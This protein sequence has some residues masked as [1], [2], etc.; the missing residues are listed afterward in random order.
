MPIMALQIKCPPLSIFLS[1]TRMSVLLAE[2]GKLSLSEYYTQFNGIN[3]FN[4][5]PMLV[6]TAASIFFA[7]FVAIFT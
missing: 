1:L 2:E 5:I 4:Q 3:F 6:V 7:V